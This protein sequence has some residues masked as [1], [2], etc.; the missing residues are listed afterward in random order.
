MQDN[1]GTVD[2]ARRRRRILLLLLTSPLLLPPLVLMSNSYH[3]TIRII[4]TITITIF[5]G[6][7]VQTYSTAAQCLNLTL[8][9][10]SV[11]VHWMYAR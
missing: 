7:V 5:V 10:L 6:I 3:T 8:K 11:Y 1:F 4:V 2:A 9:L